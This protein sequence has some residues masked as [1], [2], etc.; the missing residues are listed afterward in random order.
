V[1][2]DPTGLQIFGRIARKGGLAAFSS[3]PVPSLSVS[4]NL[5]TVK[6]NAKRLIS[7]W[8]GAESCV[9]RL[10]VTPLLTQICVK[11]ILWSTNIR[12][13]SFVIMPK[14]V[15]L[16]HGIVHSRFF[17]VSL[18]ARSSNGFLGKCGRVNNCRSRQSLR[19]VADLD[20]RESRGMRLEGRQPRMLANRRAFVCGR[21]GG[22]SVATISCT[23]AKVPPESWETQRSGSEPVV[24]I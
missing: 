13:F 11:L 17:G 3:S 1:T 10:C 23:C 22:S 16:M 9:C 12:R 6:V 7:S 4:K 24:S 21:G 2:D 8:R 15:S 19:A 14:S 20:L 18:R 5:A